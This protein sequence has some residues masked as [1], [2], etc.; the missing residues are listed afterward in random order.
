RA[1]HVGASLSSDDRAAGSAAPTPE[2]PETDASTATDAA[3]A[4]QAAPRG[5]S[6]GRI[7]IALIAAVFIL[8]VVALVLVPPY[9][10]EHPGEPVQSTSDLIIANLELPAPDIIFPAD[11][12]APPGL[13][14]WDVSITNTILTTWIVIAVVLVIALIARLTMKWIPGPFQNFYEWAF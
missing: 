3:T 7:A 9:P 4:A 6:K 8:D 11:H 10:K 13:V 2:T 14:F 5:W 12:P 1:P